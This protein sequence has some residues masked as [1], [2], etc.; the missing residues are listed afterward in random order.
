MEECKSKD[1]YCQNR[2]CKG[3]LLYCDGIR[4]AYDL[5]TPLRCNR[6]KTIR[7]MCKTCVSSR[8]FGG[9]YVL[10]KQYLWMHNQRQMKKSH[11]L[12]NNL[13]Y[14]V[15]DDVRTEIVQS[16]K[17]VPN[18]DPSVSTEI[19]ANPVDFEC[20]PIPDVPFRCTIQL[21]P[22]GETQCTIGSNYN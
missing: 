6:C 1:F 9:N 4:T 3:D 20:V 5:A 21:I 10:H 13:G 17:E 16:E 19:K 8:K 12:D 18:Y 14:R 11:V 7:F 22:G 2:I 15:S